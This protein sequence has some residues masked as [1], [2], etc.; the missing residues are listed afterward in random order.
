MRARLIVAA[1]FAALV[2]ATAMLTASQAPPRIRTFIQT[3]DGNW[4]TIVK[5]PDG[6]DVEWVYVPPTKFAA[7]LSTRLTVVDAAAAKILDEYRIDNKAVS[8]QQV[9][10]L[11]IGPG[12]PAPAQVKRTPRGWEHYVEPGWAMLAGPGY[13]PSG[14]APGSFDI[15]EI[16]ARNLPGVL[17]LRA[18]GNVGVPQIPG[19]LSEQQET[20]LAEIS[21]NSAVDLPGIGPVIPAGIGEPELTRQVLLARV[22]MHYAEPLTQYRHPHATNLIAA[23][24]RSAQETGDLGAVMDD[25]RAIC[26]ITLKP[27]SEPWHQDLST[28]LRVAVDLLIE[29]HVPLK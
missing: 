20:D 3:A 27:V 18:Q 16:E 9:A 12:M 14:I 25:L 7:T 11:H 22:A 26:A 15:V 2:S 6:K 19:E 13:P 29:G 23:M 10:W 17:M 1:G 5:G 21:K 28:A 8:A 4:R 24:R